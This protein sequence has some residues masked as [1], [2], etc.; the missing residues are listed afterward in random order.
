MYEYFPCSFEAVVRSEFGVGRKRLF[1]GVNRAIGVAGVASLD[2][3]L[4]LKKENY[5]SQ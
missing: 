4:K 3:I 1:S 5:I 2:Y